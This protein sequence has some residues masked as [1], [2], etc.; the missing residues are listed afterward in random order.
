[1]READLAQVHALN[2]LVPEAPWWSEDHLRQIVGTDNQ[3]TE[4]CARRGWVA[5]TSGGP[6]AL[7]GF[8]VLQSVSIPGERRE[9]ECESIVV[10]PAFRRRGIGK[11]L[12]DRMIE[13][14]LLHSASVLRLEVR[15]GN[16]AAI[17]LY[18]RAGFVVTGTRPRYYES[19]QEDALLMALQFPAER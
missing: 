15:R 8:T 7:A 12:L 11:Q 9:C 1:M 14:C 4:A 6:E 2:R 10:H 19:P 3:T 17:G 16:D 18:R 13:W 5:L